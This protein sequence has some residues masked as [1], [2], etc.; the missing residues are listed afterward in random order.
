[1]NTIKGSAVTAADTTLTVVAI[2]FGV[3][4][5]IGV[6]I[7]VIQLRKYKHKFR[8]KEVIEGRKIYIDDRAREYKDQGGAMW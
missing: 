5:L 1:M 8:I 2:L 6:I 4:I 7:F 3:A